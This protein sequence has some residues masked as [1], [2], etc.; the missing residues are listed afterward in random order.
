MYELTNIDINTMV[1][2]A[3]A[4]LQILAETMREYPYSILFLLLIPFLRKKKRSAHAAYIKA[5]DKA[6]LVLHTI[7]EPSHK[8]TFLRNEVNPYVFEEMILSA[9]KKNGH[10]ITRNLRYTGDGGIDGRAKIHGKKVIIQA[11]RYKSHINASDVQAFATECQR[12]KVS[13]L[14]V[15]TGKTGKLSRL[16]ASMARNIDIISGDR[17]IQLLS[18]R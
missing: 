4:L 10:K 1:F 5:A 2:Y 3:T 18:A 9:L 12:Q 8:I 17:L 7:K 15:H 6:L 13:G 11:K 14:F 16:H